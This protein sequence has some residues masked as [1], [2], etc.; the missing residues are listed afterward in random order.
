MMKPKVLYLLSGRSFSSKNVG[1]KI[2]EVISVWKRLGI[3]LDVQY[4]RDINGVNGDHHDYG[5]QK[6]YNAAFR[7]KG[8]LKMFINSASEFKDIIHNKRLFSKIKRK[9]LKNDLDLIWE[10]SSRLHSAGLKLARIKNVPFVLEWKDHLVDYNYSLFKWYANYIEKFKLEKAD[11]VIVESHVLRQELIKQGV[12]SDKIKVALNGVNPKEFKTDILNGNKLK[13]KLGINKNNTV[14]GYLGSY[15]FYHDTKVLIK[16]AKLILEKVNHINFVLVGNGKDFNKCKSLAEEYNLFD[17]GLLMLD[18]V[19]KE[20]VPNYLSF[21]DITVL[22]GSTNIICPIKIMEYMAAE[23]AVLAPDYFCNKE[24]IE[25]GINGIL[26]EPG[27]SVDLSEKIM[28][29]VQDMKKRK[30][31]GVKAR[32]YVSE[33][34]V[35]EQT[36][37]K[38]LL[39]I[40]KK[41]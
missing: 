3:E 27:N 34:L 30:E 14:I 11:Y 20:E 23:T 38:V 36:W 7:K 2:Y 24:V 9:Y 33:N 4:G 15:A 10:R 35:W 41:T 22:P 40:I 37:G 18:G 5:N 26:F 8:F 16:T 29:L 32:K 31:I 25:N 19:N 1:R 6:H 17:K 13:L 12:H 21:M 39:D 28:D